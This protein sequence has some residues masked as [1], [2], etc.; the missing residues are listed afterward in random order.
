MRL[1]L[2]ALLL[3]AGCVCTPLSQVCGGSKGP[4]PTEAEVVKQGLAEAERQWVTLGACAGP[5]V[6]STNHGVWVNPGPVDLCGDDYFFSRTGRLLAKV[7]CCESECHEWG[8]GFHM[9]RGPVTR[10]LCDEARGSL[11]LLGAEVTVV[12][13]E[14]IAA[15]DGSLATKRENGWALPFGHYTVE[16]L[17]GGR[18]PLEVLRASDGGLASPAPSPGLEVRLLFHRPGSESLK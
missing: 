12:G 17:D 14:R 16:N 11:I 3:S 2:T 8:V 13:V 1:A 5:T 6:G 10:N 18:Q 15:S 4:C 7:S 9:E